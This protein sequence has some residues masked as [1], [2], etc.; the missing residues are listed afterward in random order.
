MPDL[1]ILALP[2]L[3]IAAAALAAA[4]TRNYHINRDNGRI[5]AL[6]H[7]LEITRDDRD[8]LL[9]VVA[10]FVDAIEHRPDQ[11]D[12]VAHQARQAIDGRWTP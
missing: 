6:Q 7:G 1:S 11:L 3:I 10:R 2:V 5:T 9:Q 4:I 12:K 8:E